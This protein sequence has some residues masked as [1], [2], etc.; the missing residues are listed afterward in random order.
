MALASGDG[1]RHGRERDNSAKIA[2]TDMEME[3]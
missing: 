3:I 2:K 1:R